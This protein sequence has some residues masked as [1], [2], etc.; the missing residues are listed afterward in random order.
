VNRTLLVIGA[1]SLAMVAVLNPHR[2]VAQGNIFNYAT[3]ARATRLWIPPNLDTVRGILIYGNGAGGDSRGEVNVP[4]NQAFAIE[5]GFAVIATSMWGN[6]SGNE[7]T[8]WDSHLANLATLSAH[9]E[10]VNAPWAPIGFSNGGQMSYGFNALRPDKT[11]AFIANKGCCYNIL[12]PSTAAL[13]TPGILIAGELDTA[14]RRANIK[15]LFDVNRPRGALWSWIEQQG[16]AHSG[17]ADAM[18]LPFMAEAIRL[19]YPAGQLPSAA[20]GVTLNSVS[21]ASGW[22]VDQSTWKSGLA[23]IA[24]YENYPGV[25]ETAGWLLNENVAHVY[26]AFSTYNRDASLN[27]DLP[28]VREA[29]AGEAQRPITLK[30]NLSAAAD[31]THV[32]LFDY[33]QPIL[34][35]T[36]ATFPGNLLTLSVPVP[37]VGPY[38]FSA[39]VTHA[40]GRI[41]TTNALAYYTVPVP[42]PSGALLLGVAGLAFANRRRRIAAEAGNC[43]GGIALDCYGAPFQGS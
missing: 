4:W 25:K 28:V 7:I 43:V 34:D 11:I 10:L 39:L 13:N 27:F 3:G 16:E 22:L 32:T 18:I 42:E 29:W 9:P 2:A 35:V 21:E 19:R 1:L 24:A 26:R 15:S 23:Q 37:R 31:W 38:A 6:L 36:P 12:Q 41:S 14:V 33:A 20:G 30:L 5:H 17:R 8:T 40:D